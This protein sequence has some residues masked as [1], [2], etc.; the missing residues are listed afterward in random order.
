MLDFVPPCNR[1]LPFSTSRF[2]VISKTDK[3]SHSQYRFRAITVVACK[4]PFKKKNKKNQK[5]YFD[6]SLPSVQSKDL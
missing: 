5:V 1:P 6:L 3:Q 2:S 4:F